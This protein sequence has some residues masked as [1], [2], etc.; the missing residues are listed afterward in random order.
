MGRECR[1]RHLRPRTTLFLPVGVDGELFS[2]GD[3]HAAMGDGEVCGTAVSARWTSRCDRV[4]G[5]T[6]RSRPP[7]TSSPRGDAGGLVSAPRLNRRRCRSPRSSPRCHACARRTP[8]AAPGQGQ[9]GGLR[10]RVGGGRSAHS[11]SGRCAELG[12]RR[13][14]A[15]RNT[16]AYVGGAARAESAGGGTR[17][18]MSFRPP[19][20]KAGA[21]TGFATPAQRASILGGRRNRPALN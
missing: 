14:P 19:A 18:P 6:S 5:R 16:R 4:C 13:L 17:T 15:A 8:R 7:S 12:R 2:V 3:T 11:R 21:S 9:A 20:P 1:Y 10:D